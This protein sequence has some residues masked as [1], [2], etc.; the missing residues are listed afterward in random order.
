MD[1]RPLGRSGLSIPP[2]VLGSNVFGWTIDERTS[3]AV[4]DSFVDHGLTAIDT[5]DVYSNW[6]PGN[7]GGEAETIIGRWLASRPG[8]RDKVVLFTKVGWDLGRPGEKGLS[9][10]WVTEAAERSLAR[11]KTETIDV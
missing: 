7:S 4:L 9:R 6:V 11:L 8:A 3:F 10:R 2:L 1:I 5:A